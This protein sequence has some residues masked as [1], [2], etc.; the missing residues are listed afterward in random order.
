[1][2]RLKRRIKK[3]LDAAA[4]EKSTLVCPECGEEF[5][6]YGDA[7]LQFLAHDWS[8]DYEGETY[9]TT[10]E[11]ILRLTEHEHDPTTFINERGDPWLG[12]LF[13]GSRQMLSEPAE[14]VPDFSEGG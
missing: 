3:V 2:G 6:V 5:T 9:Q 4:D 10:P 13:R 7:A 12:E 14:N 8:L 1:M 11:D